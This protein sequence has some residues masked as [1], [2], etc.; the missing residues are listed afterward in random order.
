MVPGRELFDHTK[1][2]G[3]TMG[4]PMEAFAIAAV[5]PAP[6]WL[7]LHLPRWKAARLRYYIMKEAKLSVGLQ[8]ASCPVRPYVL[9]LKKI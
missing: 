9:T 3:C 7:W 5:W 6:W 1:L 8:W 4:R 2:L